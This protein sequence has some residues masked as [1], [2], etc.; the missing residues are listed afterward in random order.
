MR[1]ILSKIEIQKAKKTVKMFKKIQ[2]IPQNAEKIRSAAMPWFLQYMYSYPL[3][4]EHLGFPVTRR[5]RL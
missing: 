2:K 3:C 1:I 5:Q 4:K